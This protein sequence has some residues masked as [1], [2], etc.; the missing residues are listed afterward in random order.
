M[1]KGITSM[2]YNFANA[3]TIFKDTITKQ[4]WD[5]DGRTSRSDFWHYQSIAIL[6]G[7]VIGFVAGL[8][9]LPIISTLFSLALLAPGIGLY[10]RRVHDQGKV[11]WHGIIPLYNIYL[12]CLPGDKGPNAFGDDPLGNVSDT[13]S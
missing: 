6:L 5:V 10:I 11:W 7:F 13:F 9:Q 12:A 8:I 2:S 1:G 4:Y 3:V